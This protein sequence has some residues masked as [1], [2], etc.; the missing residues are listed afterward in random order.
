[1]FFFTPRDVR[2]ESE[3][4]FLKGRL[5]RWVYSNLLPRAQDRAWDLAEYKQVEPAH[6]PKQRLEE[7][8]ASKNVYGRFA[9]SA[10]YAR[11][12]SLA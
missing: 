4:G 6:C 12:L 9:L 2:G 5:P 7:R 11:A 1:M 10:L 3:S 8:A